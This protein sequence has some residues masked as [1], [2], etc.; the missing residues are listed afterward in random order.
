MKIASSLTALL[1]PGR[2]E[3]ASLLRRLEPGQQLRASVISIPRAGVAQLQIGLTAF[4][5]R[6]RM[7]LA[8]GM[9]LDLTVTKLKPVPERQLLIQP[10]PVRPRDQVLRTALPRQ[11]PLTDAL[12]GLALH[13]RGNQDRMPSDAQQVI[14]NLLARSTTP[15]QLN[16]TSIREQLRT[17]GLFLEQTMAL[18]ASPIGGD[19]KLDLLRLLRL[20]QS[21]PEQAR[22]QV[23]SGAARMTERPGSVL[24]QLIRLVEGAVARVQTQ[25]AASLP[26]DQGLRQVWQF[27]LPVLVAGQHEAVQVRV[28]HD[29]TPDDDTNQSEPR[30]SV[31]LRFDFEIT[32]TIQARVALIGET[33]ASTFWCERED[34]QR[35][36]GNALVTLEAAFKNSGLE[37]GRLTSVHGEPPE[38]IELPRPADNLLDARA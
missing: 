12:R 34:T 19:L 1:D 32:G 20:L 27:D 28:E 35:Q 4:L 10:T 31:M 8:T 33:V 9:Q 38:P 36:I 2:Q 5:A 7:P 22:T 3:S 21:Q 6:T 29:E 17:S 14:R 25:Q 13:A 37:V 11:I 23:E 24:E 30:W 18:G 26:H 15:I 16:A